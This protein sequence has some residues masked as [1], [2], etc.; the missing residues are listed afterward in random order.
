M[1]YE[2]PVPGLGQAQQCGC[3]NLLCCMLSGEAAITK[4]VVFD[5]TLP[6]T[7]NLLYSK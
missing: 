7:Y 3:V 1:T 2:N 6:K 5:L 4:F